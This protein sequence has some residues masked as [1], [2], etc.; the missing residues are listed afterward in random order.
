MY[1]LLPRAIDFNTNLQLLVFA[2]IYYLLNN[3]LIEAYKISL[4]GRLLCRRF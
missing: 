3:A 4:G 1:K 2:L